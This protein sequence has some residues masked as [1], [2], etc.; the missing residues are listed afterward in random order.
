MKYK[1]IGRIAVICLGCVAVLGILMGSGMVLSGDILLKIYSTD[2]EV[3]AYGKLRM[4]YILIPYFICGMMDVMVGLMR[5]MGYAIMP[6]LVSLTGACLFR[7]VWVYTIFQ[8]I[9]TL[10]CLYISYPISWTLTLLIH[11]VCFV[12]IY[13]KTIKKNA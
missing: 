12:T 6:M 3:I 13:R 4:H 7:V 9:R 10:E 5:G 8:Q 2:P 11:V 1:R